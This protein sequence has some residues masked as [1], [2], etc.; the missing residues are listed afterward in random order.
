MKRN[1]T[2]KTSLYLKKS[3]FE[4][5][6]AQDMPLQSDSSQSVFAQS[7]QILSGQTVTLNTVKKASGAPKY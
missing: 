6:C 2:L 4:V 7:G 1:F 3:R 5:Y